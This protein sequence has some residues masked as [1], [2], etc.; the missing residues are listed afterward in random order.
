MIKNFECYSKKESLSDNTTQ[1]EKQYEDGTRAW[2][3][4]DNRKVT[5]KK[6]RDAFKDM[7]I[8]QYLNDNRWLGI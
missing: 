7:E 8:D 1:W 5:R 2:C 4:I 6:V 3:V